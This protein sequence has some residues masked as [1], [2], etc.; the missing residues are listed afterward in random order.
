V[1]SVLSPHIWQ[2]IFFCGIL[3]ENV[4]FSPTS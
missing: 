1:E 2:R 4:P 3:I